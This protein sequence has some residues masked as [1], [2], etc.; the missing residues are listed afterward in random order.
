MSNNIRPSIS[1]W[2]LTL[3]TTCAY[4]ATESSWW[5]DIIYLLN[6]NMLFEPTSWVL[7]S[8][9]VPQT[10]VNDIL[11]YLAVNTHTHTHVLYREMTCVPRWVGRFCPPV[12]LHVSA[13][14][15]ILPARSWPSPTDF[16]K[17]V[18]QTF[19]ELLVRIYTLINRIYVRRHTRSSF[20]LLK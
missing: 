16:M 13:Y 19:S 17:T 9:Y 8:G 10:V 4:A 15:T 20:P 5:Y 3:C 14:I 11:Y 18:V 1:A 2:E 6:Y 7:G 12:S